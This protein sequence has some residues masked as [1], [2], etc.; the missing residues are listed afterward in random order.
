MLKEAFIVMIVLVSSMSLINIVASSSYGQSPVPV[1]DGWAGYSGNETIYLSKGIKAN[2][3]YLIP[4]ESTYGIQNNTSL[5]PYIDGNQRCR[6]GVVLT[7]GNGVYSSSGISPTQEHYDVKNG[8]LK[9][10]FGVSVTSA[11]NQSGLYKNQYPN[12]WR[13]CGVVADSVSTEVAGLS[14][15]SG[16]ELNSYMSGINISAPATLSTNQTIIA[17]LLLAGL[18]IVPIIGY[19]TVPLSIACAFATT[20][21]S[22]SESFNGAN[23]T[24]G[25]NQTVKLLSGNCPVIINTTGPDNQWTAKFGHN[26]VEA[27]VGQCVAINASDFGKS[28]DLILSAHDTLGCI[29][30]TVYGFGAYAVTG[31]A[32]TTLSIPMVPAYTICGMV[33]NNGDPAPNQKIM[34]SQT[35]AAGQSVNFC[36]SSDQAGQ[37]R[38][39]AQPGDSYQIREV[40]V[41]GL[42]QSTISTGTLTGEGGSYYTLNVNMTS[43]SGY[44]NDPGAFVELTNQAGAVLE[45][46]TANAYGGYTF[47]GIADTGT[48]N[49][50]AYYQGRSGGTSV[51]VMSVGNGQVIVPQGVRYTIPVTIYNNQSLS[52]PGPFDQEVTVDSSLYSFYEASDLQNVIWF[53]ANGSLIPSWIQSGDSSQS[54][55]TVY[56]LK[57]PFSL[58]SYPYIHSSAHIYMGFAA[59]GTNEF[60]SSYEGV[61]PQLT[62]PYAEYDNGKTVFEMYDNFAGTS[63]SSLWNL[64][65][66]GINTVSIDN[67][68]YMNSQYDMASAGI[69]SVNPIPGPA[70]AEAYVS[71]YTY[72]AGGPSYRA[73]AESNSN[74]FTQ[75]NYGGFAYGDGYAVMS[76]DSD[77]PHPV[78]SISDAN[79]TGESL[80]TSVASF[81]GIV[82]ISWASNGSEYS[83][84]NG[85]PDLTGSNSLNSY[86]GYFYV[87]LGLGTGGAGA[88]SMTWQW[89]RV[90]QLP[91]NNVMPSVTYGTVSSTGFSGYSYG[92]TAL[93]INIP[94]PDGSVLFSANNLPPDNTW[95]LDFGGK[96]YSVETTISL[97]EPYGTYYYSITPPSGYSANP[98]SGS[99]TIGSTEQ[100]VDIGFTQN[101][102]P[103]SSSYT[104]RFSESGLPSG[105]QWAV[106]L[107]RQEETSTSSSMDFSKSSGSYSYT[108]YAASSGSSIYSPVP[109][110]GTVD[111]TGNVNIGVTYSTNSGGGGGGGCILNGTLVSVSR[112]R[113][114]PV[115][116]LSVGDRVLSYDP[117]TGKFINNRITTINVTEVHSILS[118]DYGLLYVSGLTDQPIYVLMPNGTAQWIMVGNLTTSDYILD[119]QMGIWVPVFS[120]QIDYGNYTVYDLHGEK[121][122]YQS[123]YMRFTYMA[124]GL[125]LDRKI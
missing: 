52:T 86:P 99:V 66:N 113:Y 120:L 43:I 71:Q 90:R 125:L 107:G 42:S 100:T 57:L 50:G 68:L 81:P 118:I 121:M 101:T 102:P 48:Y 73:I 28:G 13:I 30:P 3:P 98:S 97:S 59:P 17:K 69:S 2:A 27:S 123:G 106:S 44:V 8:Q 76:A 119:P 62:S 64:R 94:A 78:L 32:S 103:P 33:E 55:S 87:S 96:D 38:F 34:L 15:V 47:N 39:F 12:C 54:S 67:H 111:V 53:L 41:T 26:V 14:M 46:T 112:N 40:T 91:P 89:V 65:N 114:V 117:I 56:W 115:Q 105:T 109:S 21:K 35:D 19:A 37:F 104:I 72:N 20:S 24:M 122:F 22:P 74:V 58:Q 63:L 93:K 60:L 7:F 108:V 11:S 124:N 16:N 70:I 110:S 88:G 92:Y 85:A 5:H 83:Y 29:L 82:G 77:G 10:D 31:G 49:I 23:S 84:Y 45:T 36:I 9:I 25:I 116:D 6:N 4:E 95:T 61:A 18:S 80:G 1:H 51:D 75:L 79:G